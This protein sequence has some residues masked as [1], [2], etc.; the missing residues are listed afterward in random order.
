MQKNMRA[1]YLVMAVACAVILASVVIVAQSVA[2][3]LIPIPNPPPPSM[4]QLGELHRLE[5]RVAN[6]ERTLRQLSTRV[7]EFNKQQLIISDEKLAEIEF[8][9]FQVNELRNWA[10]EQKTFE[11]PSSKRR[12]I[13]NK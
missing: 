6:L 5:A 1:I 8:L 13:F 4:E 2:E 10:P 7:N 12:E 11:S 9:Q 3:G